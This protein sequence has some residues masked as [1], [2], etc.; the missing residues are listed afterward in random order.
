MK[1]SVCGKKTTW[2]KSYGN[3]KFLVCHKCFEKMK[4]ENNNDTMATLKKIL[5]KC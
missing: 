3:E 5:E 4:K 1:C 2:R